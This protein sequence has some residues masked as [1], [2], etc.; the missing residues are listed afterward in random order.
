MIKLRILRWEIILDFL[1]GPDS[2]QVSLEEGGRRSERRED[3]TQLALKIEKMATSQVIQA[4]SRVRK[5]P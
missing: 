4:A 3:G 1:G 2:S 5:R